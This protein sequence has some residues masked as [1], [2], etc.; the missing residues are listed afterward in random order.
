MTGVLFPERA[1]FSSSPSNRSYGN[2]DIHR[3]MQS[4]DENWPQ[5]SPPK[6]RSCGAFPSR[7]PHAFVAWCSGTG[8]TYPIT[9]R[10]CGT[11]KRIPQTH[12]EPVIYTLSLT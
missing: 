9:L 5:N 3:V 10:N 8:S 4:Y 11:M 7:P 6:P 2:A 12:M 1:D